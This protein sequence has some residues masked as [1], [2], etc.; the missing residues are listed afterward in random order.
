M[1]L[2]ANLRV[3]R[4]EH[5]IKAENKREG[6]VRFY[7]ENDF[8]EYREQVMQED[9]SIHYYADG[10]LFDAVY[11]ENQHLSSGELYYIGENGLVWIRLMTAGELAA[12]QSVYTAWI[13]AI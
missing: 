1:T 12:M 6:V 9:Q 2:V 8:P 11:H 3:A 5:M 10:Y 13:E 7:L 4:C